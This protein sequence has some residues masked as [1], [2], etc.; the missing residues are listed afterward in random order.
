[1]P[2]IVNNWPLYFKDILIVKNKEHNVGVVT[3]WSKPEFF[4][5][6]NCNTVG[7]CYSIEGIKYILRNLAGNTNI[8]YLILCGTDLSKTG[9]LLKELFAGKYNIVI[10]DFS[11]EDLERITTN[12]ELV[13]MIEN[14][15]PSEVQEKINSLSVKQA[16]GEAK[17]IIVKEKSHSKKPSEKT[18]FVIREKNIADAWLNALKLIKEY[19]IE[20]KTAYGIGSLEIMNLVTVTNELEE[21]H[22][23][24]FMQIT[25]KQIKDYEDQ[26]CT[27]K[28]IK[29]VEY[30]YGQRLCTYFMYDQIKWAI[31]QLK[32]DKDGRRIFL[33]LWD[34]HKDKDSSL[35]PCLDSIQFLVQNN[36]LYMTAY[37]RSHDIFGAYHLNVFGLRKMQEIVAKESDLDIGELTT[38]SCSAH[39]Y[40]NDIPAAEEILKWN[41]TLKCIPDPRGY[42]FIEVKDKIYA[43][44]LNNSG[45]PVKTYSGET[46]KEVY[47]QILLDFAVSQL[48][49]AFY[50]GK[51]LSSAENALKTGKKYVQT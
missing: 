18:G 2:S 31:N 16:Y 30:T 47:N 27:G 41:Y 26:I 9:E 4:E 43:K 34:P 8:R 6:L 37:F 48:S 38:I 46:A 51:E 10:S 19:G 35:P 28:Q 24:K 50:L 42:F 21:R 22:V 39:I 29:S 25:K 45:I 1:M 49:H 14:T 33:T 13:D 3:L 7:T 11:F 15:N 23:P 5:K 40:Y 36:F 17:E 32:I 44:Y 12:V 20:K